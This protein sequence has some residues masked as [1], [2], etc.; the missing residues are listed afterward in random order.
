MGQLLQCQNPVYLQLNL[1]F[2]MGEPVITSNSIIGK[3]K[4]MPEV[5]A[6]ADE[7]LAVPRLRV[8]LVEEEKPDLAWI[9]ELHVLGDLPWHK[10]EE[11]RV[12]L[13]IM[14]DEF[15]NYV[16]L[17]CPDLIVKRGSETIGNLEFE[18]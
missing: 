11:R 2:D 9:A 12:E 1:N 7:G 5:N 13:R 10:G 3:V 6:I 14:S 4:L 17:S 15:R 8:E 16:T 18:K